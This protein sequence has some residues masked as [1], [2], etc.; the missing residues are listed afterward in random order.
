MHPDEK[1]YF[2]EY[3]SQLNGLCNIEYLGFSP[4]GFPQFRI[5][6]GSNNAGNKPTLFLEL[7]RDEEGN[8]PGF[9][10]IGKDNPNP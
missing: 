5:N 6:R 7:S 4:D 8:G 10:F 1:K 2:D 3:Y 9:L